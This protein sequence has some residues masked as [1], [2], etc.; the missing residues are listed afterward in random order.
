M[1]GKR[2]VKGDLQHSLVVTE[3]G[4]GLRVSM[5]PGVI[6]RP[7]M[8]GLHIDSSIIAPSSGNNGAKEGGMFHHANVGASGV[9]HGD[10]YSEY[11]AG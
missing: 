5:M 1:G 3:T 6:D 4:T 10:L 9:G 8:G 7:P 2:Y 11:S